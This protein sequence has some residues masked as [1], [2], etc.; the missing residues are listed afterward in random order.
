M[1]NQAYHITEIPRCQH[2]Y[3]EKT[4]AE[5]QFRR[6]DAIQRTTLPSAFG[7]WMQTILTRMIFT[8]CKSI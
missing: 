7:R 5:S 8:S 1:D 6:L 4:G 2:Q 3:M